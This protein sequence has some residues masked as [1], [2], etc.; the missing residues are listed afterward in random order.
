MPEGIG[1]LQSPRNTLDFG[2]V[3]RP[4]EITNPELH[5]QIGN[6]RSHS[7]RS[8]RLSY[9]RAGDSGLKTGCSIGAENSGH[10]VVLNGN[11]EEHTPSG[12]VRPHRVK[13]STVSY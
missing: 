10:L 6:T 4:V 13:K 7:S 1:E 8:E 11:R 5:A 12:D 9:V 3:L 2:S